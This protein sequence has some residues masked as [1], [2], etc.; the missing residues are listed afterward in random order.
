MK[1]KYEE[2]L[3]SVIEE[4]DW[5]SRNKLNQ[6]LA[7]RY[8]VSMLTMQLIKKI[9]KMGWSTFEV[10][11]NLINQSYFS[12]SEELSSL[13]FTPVGIKI[14]K[15]FASLGGFEILHNFYMNRLLPLTIYHIGEE[16]RLKYNQIN[17]V[18]KLRNSM[19][20]Q[21]LYKR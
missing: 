17:N 9:L 21:L 7:T 3:I 16:Y 5:I 15:H 18:N 4:T 19:I 8:N 1:K 10:T 20:M 11:V 2:F 14:E 6:S 13:V 12:F